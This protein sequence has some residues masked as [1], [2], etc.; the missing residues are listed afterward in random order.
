MAGLENNQRIL[1]GICTCYMRRGW[2]VK[3][4]SWLVQTIKSSGDIPDIG[5]GGNWGCDMM[6]S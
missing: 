1:G 5:G 2:I 4:I 6:V 3:L